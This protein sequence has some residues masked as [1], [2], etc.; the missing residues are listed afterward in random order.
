MDNDPVPGCPTTHNPWAG[1]ADG[2]AS[3]ES[4][5]ALL[6]V[7][8]VGLTGAAL[9][10]AIAAA[11]KALSLLAGVQMR[12]QAALAVPF[13]AG[14]P[15]RLANR[16]GRKSCIP[17]DDDIHT[18]LFVPEAAVSLAAGEIAAALRISPITAGIRV[19]SAQ[20][21]TTVLAPTLTAMETG[22]LDRGKAMIIAEHCAPLSPEHTTAVQDLVLRRAGSLSN[23]ELRDLTGEA[24]IT[25]DPDGARERHDH[26]AARRALVLNALPD[27]M[28]CLR[29]TLPADGAVKIF[30]LSDLLATATAGAPDDLR[31]I[32]A[33]RADA[34]VDVAEQ[35]LTHGH[36]DLTGYLGAPLPDHSSPS[37]RSSRPKT[38][39]RSTPDNDEA[40]TNNADGIDSTEARCQIGGSAGDPQSDLD[41]FAPGDVS[42]TE[43]ED[44]EDHTDTDTDTGTGLQAR[45]TVGAASDGAPGQQ[46]LPR[47]GPASAPTDQAL[48]DRRSLTRQG[49]RPH[50]SVVIGVETLAG[51]NDLPARLAG[52]GAIPAGIARSIAAS[53][54]TISTLTADPNTGTATHAGAL[55]YRPR[56]ELRDQITALLS[57]CQF[58]SCRQPSWRCDIDHRES[59]DH[60]HPDSGGP[61]T[62]GNTAPLCR[63][64]H[65]FK[66]HS[67]W[68]VAMDPADFVITWTSPTGHGYERAQQQVL[69]PKM[70]ITNPASAV[71]EHLDGRQATTIVTATAASLAAR[72]TTR[73][74][75]TATAIA[76]ATATGNLNEND[77]KIQTSG[78]PNGP[79]TIEAAT[80]GIQAFIAD[81]LLRQH[82][83]PTP[84]EYVPDPSVWGID[85]GTDSPSLRYRESGDTSQ[86][87]GEDSPPF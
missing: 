30:Q 39:D 69:T 15:T 34:L 86:Q 72:S 13:I 59:F 40:N 25:V 42:W 35:L 79:S 46:A 1:I 44:K 67:D 37:P 78:S 76:I 82:L 33:R 83:R 10:D 57:T 41:V 51:L 87:S 6:D 47:P 5:T 73:A 68:H 19:R 26:A 60:H 81:A 27:A 2:A 16:L 61:T 84:M 12:L 43:S 55:T 54:A 3:V 31:G 62:A 80:G 20:D 52:Y 74:T 65:L 14:D 71:A 22:V 32:A 28:A 64:H 50:L 66:H 21:M 77:D 36:L 18:A 7:D 8:P 11:E 53:A 58:P 17:G 38:G 75:A 23:G 24:V 9:V 70:W 45:P 85:S 56:Q 63:R 49:R 48:R 29:A 4:V